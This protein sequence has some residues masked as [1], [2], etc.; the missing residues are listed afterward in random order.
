MELQ[1]DFND[2]RV[3]SPDAKVSLLVGTISEMT[4]SFEAKGS[5]VSLA[6]ESIVKMLNLNSA[7]DFTGQGNIETANINASGTTIDITTQAGLE[8]AVTAGKAKKATISAA[9]ANTMIST[10]GLAAGK[11]KVI[12]VD[13]AGNLS[14]ESTGTVILVPGPVNAN[15][16]DIPNCT[17]CHPDH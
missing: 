14:A 12:A 5:D 7:A 15:P 9:N 4:L 2:V 8:D 1:G 10:R 3:E 6:N 11:Y 16:G 17:S 13:A